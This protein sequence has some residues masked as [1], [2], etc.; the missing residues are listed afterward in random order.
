[1]RRFH[2]YGPVNDTLH[3]YT[4]REKLISGAFAHLAGENPLEGGHYFTVW[5]PR[6]CGKSWVMLQVLHMIE[7]K[8]HIFENSTIPL[9][10]VKIDLDPPEDDT[11]ID[12]IAASIARNI[13]IQ[14]GKNNPGITTLKQFPE[15]FT[16]DVL[17]NPLAL[18]ID[19]FD[20]LPTDAIN[21]LTRVF[22]NIY[23]QKQTELRKPISERR[24]MLHGLALIGVRSILGI[25]NQQGSPFNVQ[26]SLHIPYLTF[27]EVN[28]MFQWYEKESGQTVEHD[29]I[30]RL[31]NETNGQPGLIGWFGELMTEGFERYTNNTNKPITMREF[32]IV[33]AA[34]T[35]ALPNNNILNLISKAKLEE[36]KKLVLDMFQPGE[37]LGFK[38]DDKIMNG[39]YMNGLADYEIDTQDKYYIKFACPFVQKRLFNYFSNEYFNY[40]GRLVDPFTN[41]DDAIS[42]T[43]LDIIPLLKLYQLYLDKNKNWL[44][45]NVPR[46]SDQRIVEAVFHFNFYSYFHEFLRGKNVNVIPEFP[47]GNG[48]IDIL[49]QYR[50]KKYGIELKS[51]RDS[52][53]FK[54][55]REKAAHYGKQMGLAEIF[56]VSF[57][58]S[59]DEKTRET[60]EKDFYDPGSGVTVKPFFIQTG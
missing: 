21:R 54:I 25:E 17:Q 19:E 50:D 44:F 36:N 37:K 28:G 8:Q 55:A 27:D 56:L 45:E 43:D 11:D 29:V 12:S 5:A 1:M 52:S 10:G 58:E 57:I 24:Y 13:F 14:L 39:L 22:R 18:I 42:P 60:N 3:Y 38:F 32:E 6:Q 49:L 35:Y 23:M 16:R 47:T 31:Y 33:Y 59:I 26:R 51:F 30:E 40:M 46:R 4:P 20:S 48:K 15:L 34:A 7:S 2:S 9:D 41:L 53:A